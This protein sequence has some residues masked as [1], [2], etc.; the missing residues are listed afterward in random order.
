M[1][2]DQMPSVDKGH[3][4]W[5]KAWKEIYLVDLEL[6]SFFKNSFSCLGPDIS[7][8]YPYS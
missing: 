6:T 7:G 4:I 1:T 5:L 8:S 3:D 2:T